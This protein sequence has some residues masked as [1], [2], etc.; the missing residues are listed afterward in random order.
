MLA[1]GPRAGSAPILNFYMGKITPERKGKIMDKLVVRVGK[2]TQVKRARSFV[3]K[4]VAIIGSDGVLRGH[5]SR[6]ATALG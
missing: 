1:H 4:N 3:Q 2:E 6:G 5:P